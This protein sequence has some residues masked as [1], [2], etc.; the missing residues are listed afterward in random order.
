M[1]FATRPLRFSA[2]LA[3]ALA[4]G[5]AAGAPAQAEKLRL[6]NEGVFPPFS[7]VDADGTVKGVEPDLARE[8]CKRMKVECEI[9]VMDFKALIPSL[10]QGKFDVLISQLLMTTERRQRLTLTRRLFVNPSTFVVAKNSNYTF[11]KEGLKGKGMKLGL[12][13]GGANSKWAQETFGDSIE[14]VYYENPD[15]MK[16]DL[17]AGRVN[18]LVMLKINAAT[19]ILMKPEGKDWKIDGGEYNIGQDDIPE[20]ERGLTW[21]VRKGEDGLVKR[22]NAA[23]D[24]IIA[25]CTFTAIRKKYL[26][27]AVLPEDAACVTKGM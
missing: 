18:A 2:T 14:Y 20:G 6:G 16:L 10:T 17:F 19:Q 21:A 7:M 24:T 13:K 9:Q 27:V 8:M 1:A 4:A 11:T 15:Q 5:I 23:L 22:L 12:Q 3:I 25:D 26:D